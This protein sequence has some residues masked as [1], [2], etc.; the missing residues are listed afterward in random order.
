MTH[1]TQ[2]VVSNTGTTTCFL[3]LIYRTYTGH[4]LRIQIKEITFF[5]L[6]HALLDL[7]HSC[8][9]AASAV[10]VTRLEMVGRQKFGRSEALCFLSGAASCFASPPLQ[11]GSP[12]D[13]RLWQP[14]SCLNCF[15]SMMTEA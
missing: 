1:I 8:G 4:Q 3:L 6:M 13:P 7:Q 10:S 2:I 11:Q 12:Q 15:P 9:Q 5:T 14:E